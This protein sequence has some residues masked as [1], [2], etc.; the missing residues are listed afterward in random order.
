[1]TA[2]ALQRIRIVDDDESLRE[3]IAFVLE[4]EGYAVVEY[5]S[6]EDFLARDDLRTPGCLLLDVK[7]PGISGLGLFERLREAGVTLP[8]IFL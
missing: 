3:A 1:M 8:V 4:G 7:M 2:P 5:E 6:A